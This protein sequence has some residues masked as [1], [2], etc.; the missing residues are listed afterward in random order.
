MVEIVRLR[1]AGRW[2]QVKFADV[3]GPRRSLHPGDCTRYSAY[4]L[5]IARQPYRADSAQV[6]K[7]IAHDLS[8]TRQGLRVLLP[9]VRLRGYISLVPSAILPTSY[10]GSGNVRDANLGRVRLEVGSGVRGRVG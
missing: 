2:S 3:L 6:R 7:T 4:E 5:N 8:F 1:L 10:R 9:S